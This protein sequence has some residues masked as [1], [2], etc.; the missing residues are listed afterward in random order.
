MTTDSA[1][2]AET[3]LCP[4]LVA[5]EHQFEALLADLHAHTTIA[6]DTESNSLYAYRERVCLIQFSTASGDY[7]LDPLSDIDL[8]SLGDVFADAE[9]E[10]IFHAAEYDVMTMRRD[11]GF[12]F[13]RLFDTMWAARILGWPQ[14]GLGSILESTFGVQTNKRYQRYNWGKRPLDEEALIYACRD[15]HF[16]IPLR[17]IQ[18]SALERRGRWDEAQEVFDEMAAVEALPRTFDPQSFRRIKGALKLAPRQQAILY[19]LNNWRDREARR[20]DSPPFKILGNGTLL[21][22]AKA[23]PHTKS[24]LSGIRG[25]RPHHVRR[26]G[27]QILRAVKIGSRT[28]P[29]PPPPPPP[30]HSRAEM[31][32]F[33]A[34]KSWRKRAADRRGVDPDVVVGNQVLWTLAE[35]DPSTR[36]AMVGID[37]LGPW[38]RESYGAAILRVLRDL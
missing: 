3:T 37:G 1:R 10:K 30:R 15:T 25:L 9:R 13:S 2:A 26:Y 19:Q 34:L 14:V 36:D 35:R 17:D 32:R 4:T 38:K 12:E 20:K 27:E 29:P 28:K 24:D 7:L 16:L 31:Q 21:E 33:R 11:F 23:R 5:D 6:V 22:L 18:A 8:S